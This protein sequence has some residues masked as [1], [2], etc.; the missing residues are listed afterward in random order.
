MSFEKHGTYLLP[1]ILLWKILFQ[2]KI[3]LRN[4]TNKS[5]GYLVD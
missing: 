4:R 5:F 3:L 1:Q 2:N